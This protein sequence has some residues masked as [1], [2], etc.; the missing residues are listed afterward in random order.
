MLTRGDGGDAEGLLAHG[1]R[2]PQGS[3]VRGRGRRLRPSKVLVR[4][5]VVLMTHMLHRG[6]WDQDMRLGAPQVGEVMLVWWQQEA[7]TQL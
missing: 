5:A 1:A 3:H 2:G 7:L 6:W 4:L